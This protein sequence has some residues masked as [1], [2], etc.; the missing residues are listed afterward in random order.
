MQVNETHEIGFEKAWGR[1]NKLRKKNQ[2][3]RFLTLVVGRSENASFRSACGAIE[4]LASSIRQISY[5]YAYG[6]GDARHVHLL[7]LAPFL[8]QTTWSDLWGLSSGFKVVYIEKITG[9]N[10]LENYL[11][12]VIKHPYEV[13]LLENSFVA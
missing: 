12:D 13:A 6:T 10:E 7:V 4:R 8:L 9:E 11:K 2:Q 1:L 5:F 3:I